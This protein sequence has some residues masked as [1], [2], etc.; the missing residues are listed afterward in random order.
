MLAAYN[1]PEPSALSLLFLASVGLAV[2]GVFRRK[3]VQMMAT[4]LA[5]VLAAVGAVPQQAEGAQIAW[6]LP[7]PVQTPADVI[8]IPG[9]T[10]HFAA[11]F[12]TAA[13]FGA[14]PVI[15][16]GIAFTQVGA[17]GIPGLLTHSFSS[18]PNFGAAAFPGGT[19][20]TGLDNLLN[21]HS[22]HPGNPV[23]AM[24]TLEGLTIGAPYQVQV[25]GA[26]DTRAC[27]AARTYE[28]D[29]G[30]GNFGTG[31]TIQ[32]GMF[33]SIVGTFTA[34]ATTQTFQWRSLNDAAGNNDPSM[35]GLVVTLGALTGPITLDL[36]VNTTTGQVTLKNDTAGPFEIRGYEVTSVGGSLNAAGWTVPT[37]WSKAGGASANALLAAA[38]DEANFAML[39]AGGSIPLGTAYNTTINSQDLSVRFLTAEGTLRPGIVSY[40]TG[41]PVGVTGDYNNNGTVDA[42]DYVAWRNALGS[43]TTLPNDSTPGMVTQEDYGAWRANFG[44]TVGAGA[45]FA[46]SATVPEPNAV[47]L[48]V[49]TCV[50]ILFGRRRTATLNLALVIR[51][52]ALVLIAALATFA[53]EQVANANAYVDRFYRFG[54]DAT[55]DAANA[56]G[57]VVGSGPA[58]VNPQA[59]LDSAGTDTVNF[60]DFQDLDRFSEPTY[61]NVSVTGPNLAQARPGAAAGSRGIRFDGVDDHLRGARLNFPQSSTASVLSTVQPPGPLNYTGIANRGLQLWVY[62]TGPNP[63]TIQSVV[64]DLNQHGVRINAAGN[65]E[66]RYNGAIVNSNRAAA[67]N[68]WSHVMVARPFGAAPP[69]GGSILYL[70]GEAIAAAGGDYNQAPTPNDF[71]V[72]GG[73][74]ADANQLVDAEFFRGVVDDMNMFVI[75]TVATA[76]PAPGTYNFEFGKDN[77][78]ATLPVAI[79]GLSGIAGDVNQDGLVNQNDINDLVTGWNKEKRINNVRVGD[80]LTIRDGDLNFDGITNLADVFVLHDALLAG[81]GSGFDFSRLP[82]GVP[83]PS[84]LV[85]VTLTF[86]LLNGCRIGRS[87]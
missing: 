10:V 82:G 69:N 50:A 28:P 38:L 17:A 68:Q 65:W 35:S 25:I 72:V 33:Q 34:D 52:L 71:L 73:D 46:G 77:T 85:L 13:G 80:K 64:S 3:S 22:W 12:N 37:G 54:D 47:A 18:G 44:K 60:T 55:E 57:G 63:G 43:A 86:I 15:I 31:A 74:P 19:G 51:R 67:F 32:R 26:G 56:P 11:D 1:V 83:E 8:A 14:G 75:G 9:G 62:P 36:Q 66:M 5:V 58:N 2:S 45:D 49:S 41:P 21:S 61:I 59:T 23:T 79:S 27:C 42:A 6:D 4:G 24:V 39:G 84:A 29:D 48:L 16:N 78:F 87:H 7:F 40:V 76:P 81:T 53:L 30:L 20:S 70:N